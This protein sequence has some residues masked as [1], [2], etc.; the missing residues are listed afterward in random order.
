E[1]LDCAVT[2]WP[3]GLD[4]SP[5]RKLVDSA[6]AASCVPFVDAVCDDPDGIL[7]GR[8]ALSDAP[9]RLAPFDATAHAN[10]N[11]A[12]I[13]ASG[14]GKSYALGVL[15]LGAAARGVGSIVID[16]EGE[17]AGLVRALGGEVLELRPGC[18]SALNIFECGDVAAPAADRLAEV[19]G[20]VV[21]LVDVLSGGLNEVARAHVDAAAHAA[22]AR[23]AA[24]DRVP[25]LGDCIAPL[26][27]ALP[28]VATVL[29]RFC[30]GP[31]GDLFNR[32]TSIRLGAG[33]VGVSLRDLRDELIAPATLVVA[34]WLW[35][36]VRRDRRERHLVFDE[37]GLLC[38]HAPLR[39][40]LA[41]LARRCRK[42]RASLVIATQNAGDLLSTEEGRVMATNPA[43]VL[44]G[45]HRGAETLRMEQAY[46]LTPRQRASLE[47]AARGEF[48]LLA[49]ARRVPIRIEASPLHHALL[50]GE[51]LPVTVTRPA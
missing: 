14:R 5:R 8:A 34:E 28:P 10:A 23:A 48:L 1:H 40:L 15:V 13:A 51:P 39:R 12:V 41:Q 44:L 32:P 26:R 45:G 30:T 21:A 20:A 11:V 22:V 29:D 35:A 42:Y 37:V 27:S 38:A 50:T 18:G 17:H 7:L 31:I 43:I 2:T 33:I 49:G 9:I 16:P 36:L 24:E 25:L 3:I 4:R 46:A 47:G 6:A 19:T